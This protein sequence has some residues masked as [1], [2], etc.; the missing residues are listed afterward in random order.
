MP[1]VLFFRHPLRHFFG[2]E[3]F[4]KHIASVLPTDGAGVVVMVVQQFM[5]LID[6]RVQRIT[7]EVRQ[8]DSLCL[9]FEPGP[10]LPQCPP[11]WRLNRVESVGKMTQKKPAR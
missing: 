8:F 10:S 5:R 2:G 9:E 1:G 7:A 3:G 11:S 4:V 6:E